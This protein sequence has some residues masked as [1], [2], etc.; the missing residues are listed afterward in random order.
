MEYENCFEKNNFSSIEKLRA[1]V[2]YKPHV[3]K[4]LIRALYVPSF[5]YALTFSLCICYA[6]KTDS[7]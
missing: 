6:Y 7:N 2:P 5:F 4:C 1:F 3:P